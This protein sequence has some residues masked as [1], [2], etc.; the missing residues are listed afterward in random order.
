MRPPPAATAT[1]PSPNAC[2]AVTRLEPVSIRSRRPG[3]SRRRLR[4]RHEQGGGHRR[5]RG[6]QRGRRHQHRH[7]PAA[8][9]RRGEAQ[10]AARGLHELAAAVVAVAGILGHP[11]GQDGVDGTRQLGAVRGRER[12][13]LLQVGVDDRQ[14]RAPAVR[15]RSAQALVEQAGQAVLVR[16]AVERVAADLL[17]GDV[18]DG[19]HAAVRRPGRGR[20][21]S[22]SG[23]SRRGSS[24]RAPPRDRRGR[25]PA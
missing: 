9:R 19:A 8:G 16:A 20:R 10:G 15:G 12:G 25:C 4:R 18:V 2:D 21:C 3:A 13:L 22:G 7:A 23:R 14:V 11:P 6:Q 24:A 5:G 1:G 17:G